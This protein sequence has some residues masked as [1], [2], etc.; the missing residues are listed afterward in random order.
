MDAPN[1]EVFEHLK[2]G[3][4]SKE[5]ARLSALN[6]RKKAIDE[7]MKDLRM[8]LGVAL[9]TVGVKSVMWKGRPVTLQE[10]KGRKNLDKV[11]LQLVLVEEG[12][13]AQLVMDSIDKASTIGKPSTTVVLGARK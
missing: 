13:P 1:Y 7:E 4:F 11:K 8:N 5:V 10:R 3:T 6:D 9:D 12:V 2:Q